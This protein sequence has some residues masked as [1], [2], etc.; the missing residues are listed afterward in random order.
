MG[1]SIISAVWAHIGQSGWQKIAGTG[2]GT[3]SRDWDTGT[4]ETGWTASLLHIDYLQNI[5][6]GY[7]D[8]VLPHTMLS[9]Q[10]STG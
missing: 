4:W 5:K 10:S 9:P 3:G 2:T 7:P 1:L 8:R 6:G